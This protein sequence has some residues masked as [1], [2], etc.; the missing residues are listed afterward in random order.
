MKAGCAV[1]D[2]TI[3]ELMTDAPVAVHPHTSLAA[4][5]ASMVTTASA[6]CP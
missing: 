2:L 1:G 5:T 3:A 6:G 4:A